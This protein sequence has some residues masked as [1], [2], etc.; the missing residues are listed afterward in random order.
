MIP[1][2]AET[3]KTRDTVQKR[4]ATL[5]IYKARLIRPLVET[6]LAEILLV[7]A[8]QG[9]AVLKIYHKDDAGNEAACP[10]LMRAWTQS[11]AMA[12]VFDWRADSLLMAHLDGPALGDLTRSGRDREACVLLAQT[13]EQLHATPPRS[14]PAMPRLEDWVQAL[15]SLSF[16]PECPVGL[17]RDMTAA[18]EM[19]RALMTSAPAPVALHGDL[20][21]DNVILT[22]DGPRAFDAKGLTGE[23]AYDLANALRNPKGAAAE[24]NDPERLR[25]CIALYARALNV[26]PGRMAAWGFVKS[27]LSITWRSKGR[28]VSDTEAALL[29]LLHAEARQRENGPVNL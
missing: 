13:A 9:E 7:A 11:G 17:R 29:S 4:D 27:A 2:A 24:V 19:A 3:G 25:A 22:G 14:V 23:R 12:E 5:A 18:Q 20:H 8:P 1:S 28:L 10:A 21:H 6:A 16:A 26:P 15:L